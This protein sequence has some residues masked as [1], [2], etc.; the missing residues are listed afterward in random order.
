MT[1]AG[2]AS[3]HWTG[4]AFGTTALTGDG[5]VQWRVNK[6]GIRIMLGLSEANGPDAASS[7]Q[8]IKYALYI[9]NSRNCQVREMG[10]ANLAGTAPAYTTSTLFK[11]QR[12]GGAF[13]VQSL[14]G[15]G[16]VSAVIS[17]LGSRSM[18]GLSEVNGADATN[19]YQS[20]KYAIN[21]SPTNGTRKAYGL[22][23]VVTIQRS[24]STITY[25]LDETKLYTSAVPSTAP[26]FADAAMAQYGD[27]W[28]NCLL[29]QGAIK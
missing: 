20:I 4:N 15:D 27:A 22:H 19:N 21:A 2:D 24:G 7:W 11:V 12:A 16:A 5:Y 14:R 13:S 29:Y 18:I 9:T 1:G 17:R 28:L 23:S 10:G 25:W 6:T 26:L 8:S 3:D